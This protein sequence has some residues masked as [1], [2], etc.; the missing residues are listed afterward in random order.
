M[1]GKN[2]RDFG[3]GHSDIERARDIAIAA[4]QFLAE[5]TE[6]L[7]RFLSLSGIEAR[8]IRSAAQEPG[9]LAG[10]VDHLLADEL[11]LLVFAKESD[12]HP[13]EVRKARVAL[14]GGSTEPE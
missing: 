13:G 3:I 9:F 7:A 4:L 1:I 2:R 12:I 8:S 14:S 5:D 6:R 11:L 10:V